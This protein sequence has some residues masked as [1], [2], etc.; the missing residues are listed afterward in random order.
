MLKM[1]FDIERAGHQQTGLHKHVFNGKTMGTRYSAIIMSEEV[2][3]AEG[4]EEA[5][6]A[7]VDRV[8]RQ[9]STWN[10]D[11]DLMQLNRAK[12]DVWT[13]VPADLFKV[14]EG[15]IAINRASSGLF[16]PAVGSIVDA[17]GFGATS[18]EPDVKSIGEQLRQTRMPTHALLELDPEQQA[19]LKKAQVKLDLCGIAKGYG[20]DAMAEVLKAFDIKSGLVGIDGEM[21]AIGPKVKDVPWSIALE[22]PDYNLRE[23]FGMVHLQDAAI[24]TSGDYRHWVKV[25]N[26]TFSHTM[27][28]RRNGPLQNNVAS[29]SVIAEHCMTADAWATALMVMGAEA[30]L[31]VA[32]AKGINALFLIR[33]GETLK[34]ISVGPAFESTSSDY[35]STCWI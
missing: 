8:D 10:P 32:R 5:L 21:R 1:S 20:V 7:A 29:V 18:R 12:V 33:D 13:K 17:W 16:D 26:R 22:K 30:G 14:L 15:A 9:M 28:P 11:S 34:Q 6:Y 27:D 24:A 23:A 35:R 19:V 3:P 25:G 2:Q 4:L 31:H